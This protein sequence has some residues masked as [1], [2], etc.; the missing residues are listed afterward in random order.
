MLGRQAST[1][2]APMMIHGVEAGESSPHWLACRHVP[3][4]MLGILILSQV[5]DHSA[6]TMLGHNLLRNLLDNGDHFDQKVVLVRPE[7]GQ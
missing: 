3:V 5:S 2:L 4:Q 7:R 1:K 6:S